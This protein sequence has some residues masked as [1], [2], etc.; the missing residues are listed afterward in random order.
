MNIMVFD[1]ETANLEK[2]F[3]HPKYVI[4]D[5]KY[6]RE[7]LAIMG[8]GFFRTFWRKIESIIRLI[9]F[10]DFAEKKKALKKKFH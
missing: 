10:S 7:V 3:A 8:D 2:P 9:L 4:E 6:A 5:T 1:T